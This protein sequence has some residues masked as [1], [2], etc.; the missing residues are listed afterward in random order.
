MPAHTLGGRLV[1]RQTT[2]GL[3]QQESARRIGVD[4]GTLAR[5]ER[6]EREPTGV[7][8]RRVKSFFVDEDARLRMQW[9]PLLKIER[10]T[11]AG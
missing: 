8:L 6:G 9:L 1:R 2:L 5:W 11:E 7:L 3:S 4:P 10:Q